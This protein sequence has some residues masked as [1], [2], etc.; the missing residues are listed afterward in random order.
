MSVNNFHVQTKSYDILMFFLNAYITFNYFKIVLEYCQ[1]DYFCWRKI[2]RKCWQ[3]ISHGGN[4]HDT[5][6]THISFIKACGFYFR[7]GVIFVMKTIGLKM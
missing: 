2:S 7:V 1:R 6:V 4:F 3:D 5:T